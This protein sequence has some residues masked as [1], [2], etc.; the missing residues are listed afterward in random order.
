MSA[1]YPSFSS[2]FDSFPLLEKRVL[3]ELVRTLVEFDELDETLD[4]DVT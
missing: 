3:A 4:C 2:I 1:Q